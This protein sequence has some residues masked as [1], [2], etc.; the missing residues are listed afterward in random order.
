MAMPAKDCLLPHDVPQ[1]G[2]AGLQRLVGLVG[3][4][5]VRAVVVRGAGRRAPLMAGAADGRRR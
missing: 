1:P 5:G 4:V 3:L 2:P